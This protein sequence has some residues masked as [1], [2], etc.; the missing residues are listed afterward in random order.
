MY[1]NPLDVTMYFVRVWSYASQSNVPMNI[2]EVFANV[3][4]HFVKL[5][6][7]YFATYHM[8]TRITV[9]LCTLLNYQ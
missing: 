8:Y 6:K 2:R 9:V 5:K 1:L 4:E 3:H 7:L